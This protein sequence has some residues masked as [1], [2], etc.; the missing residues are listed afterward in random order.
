MVGKIYYFIS[1]ILFLSGAFIFLTPSLLTPDL[2][3]PERIDSAYIVYH[4][5]Q[6][7]GIDTILLNPK[8]LELDYSDIRVKT[9]DGILLKGW[10]VASA[11]TPA[12]T[13]IIIHDLNESSI[14]YLDHLKQFHDRGMNVAVFDLRAHGES[15]G[16][17]FSPGLTSVSDLKLLTDSVLAKKGTKHL[18]FYG[19]GLGA[20]IALQAAVYDNRCNGIILQN[21][22]S[23]FESYLERYA[24][25]KWKGMNGFWLPVF[26][27]RVAELLQYPISELDLRQIASYTD[28]PVL[29]IIGAD[30]AKVSTAETLQ[31]YDASA[32]DKKELFLVRKASHDN[33]A[34]VGGEAFYNKV[35]AFIISSMPKEQKISR[36][37]KLAFQ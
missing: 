5:A 2:I 20:A 9:V 22:F 19:A 1:A 29:F 26:K 25:D 12:N 36:Y 8:D 28:L 24:L 34:K 32:S 13:I 33:I 7:E 27:R 31:V 18:V 11:D 15:G 21:P 30:D 6:M 16:S 4:A 37:K 23:T 17:E 10:F 35:T 3:Y 14:L